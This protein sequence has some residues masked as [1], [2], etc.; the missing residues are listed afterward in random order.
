MSKREIYPNAPIVLVA[1]EVRHSLCDPLDARAVSKIAA[2][3]GDVLPLRSE[4]QEMS[5]VLAT[6]PTPQPS[7]PAVVPRWT[8]REKRTAMTVRPQAILVETTNY[9]RYESLRSLIGQVLKARS[10]TARGVGVERIGLRY[11][12]EIRVPPDNGDSSTSWNEW[13]HPSLLGPMDVCSDAGLTP[14][15]HQGIALFQAGDDQVLALRYGP[16]EGYAVASTP[17]LRRPMPPPSPYFLMDIDS[18]WQP[19]GTLPEMDVETVLAC[20][21]RLHVPVREVFEC[22]ITERLRKEV[23]R[24]E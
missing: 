14:T 12:D 1:L 22:L 11:I 2:L 19:S 17:E 9:E 5:I 23:L 3:L 16:R 8:S 13:V 6:G 15:E 18:F 20:I 7:Q 4:A 21:D 24:D 10:A